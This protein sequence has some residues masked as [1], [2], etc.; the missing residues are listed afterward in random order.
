MSA[1]GEDLRTGVGT[2]AGKMVIVRDP[3]KLQALMDK[4][5]QKGLQIGF[6]PTMGY[7]H[8]GHASLIRAAREQSDIVALSIFVN[9]TQFD[10]SED[11]DQ[12]AV[13]HSRA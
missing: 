13:G 12:G 3:S 9:P 6:V 10:P 11:L 2:E 5:R 4:A 1:S 7:L 8:E